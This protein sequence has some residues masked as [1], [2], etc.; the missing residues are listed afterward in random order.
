MPNYYQLPKPIKKY[1]Y[2]ALNKTV[3]EERTSLP[4]LKLMERK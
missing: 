1:S 2:N 3:E 4:K